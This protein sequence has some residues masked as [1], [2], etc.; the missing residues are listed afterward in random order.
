MFVINRSVLNMEPTLIV[1]LNVLCHDHDGDVL[2][3][4]FEKNLR[5]W[6]R[7]ITCVKRTARVFVSI[8]FNVPALTPC[9]DPNEIAL[10][11][12]ETITSFV[13]YGIQTSLTDKVGQT[14]SVR[15]G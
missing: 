11:L 6:S 14:P 2:S 12:P 15:E 7:S 13:I 4:R 10:Q 5:W 8:D 9:L 1:V 3:I